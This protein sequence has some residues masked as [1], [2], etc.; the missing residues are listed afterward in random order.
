MMKENTGEA[1]KAQETSSGFLESFE[2]IGKDE[3]GLEYLSKNMNKISLSE[4]QALIPEVRT[5][6]PINEETKEL[7]QKVLNSLQEKISDSQKAIEEQQKQGEAKEQQAKEDLQKLRGELYDE[8]KLK[9]TIKET[10][11]AKQAKASVP[12]EPV[13]KNWL[14]RLLNRGE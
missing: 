1:Y 4:A 14:S 5:V 7:I 12:N 11:W 9:P 6:E 13:K 10:D 8:E 3:A 2:E